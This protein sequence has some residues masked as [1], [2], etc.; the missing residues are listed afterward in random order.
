MAEGWRAPRGWA[1]SREDG[2]EEVAMVI[3]VTKLLVAMMVKSTGSRM[4]GLECE[5]SQAR[6]CFSRFSSPTDFQRGGRQRCVVIITLDS[7]RQRAV[8]TYPTPNTDFTPCRSLGTPAADQIGRSGGRADQTGASVSR[9][10][11]ADDKGRHD[12]VNRAAGKL[13]RGTIKWQ[14]RPPLSNV[15]HR[16]GPQAW[17]AGKS[18]ASSHVQ[19]RKGR[20]F[21]SVL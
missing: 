21:A 6:A 20:Q 2:P 7:P 16:L 4:N 13:R 18:Q 14:S 1:D 17:A 11:V 5:R 10:L 9:R 8:Q 15:I 3:Q 19:P 12:P